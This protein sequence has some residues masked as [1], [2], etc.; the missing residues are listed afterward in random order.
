MFS[1]LNIYLLES[2]NTPPKH[3]EDVDKHSNIASLEQ[4]SHSLKRRHSII[5]KDSQPCRSQVH[6][7]E[8][9]TV[10]RSLWHDH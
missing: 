7:E 8:G 9:R 6:K 5:P 4:Y 1:R 3:W 10:G 2:Q